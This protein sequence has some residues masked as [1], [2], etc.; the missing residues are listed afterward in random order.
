MTRMGISK[1]LF[2]RVSLNSLFGESLWMI[3]LGESLWGVSLDE[4][5]RVILFGRVSLGIYISPYLAGFHTFTVHN[6]GVLL[7][8]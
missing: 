8:Y 6:C 4:S 5:L 2:A 3:F 7:F 1:S